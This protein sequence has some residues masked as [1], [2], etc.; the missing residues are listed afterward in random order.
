MGIYLK[1][2][3]KPVVFVLVLLLSL[4]TVSSGGIVKGK[5]DADDVENGSK[6]AYVG[7]GFWYYVRDYTFRDKLTLDQCLDFCT[8]HRQQRG[9]EWN[10][11]SYWIKD[12]DC[13]CH[14]NAEYFWSDSNAVAYKFK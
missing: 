6:P 12:R 11:L 3:M 9:D 4:T 2:K 14:K 13:L 5:K 7:K 10:A 8:Q 1:F